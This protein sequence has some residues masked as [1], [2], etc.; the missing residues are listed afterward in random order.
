VTESRQMIITG[1][2]PGELEDLCSRLRYYRGWAA[3]IRDRKDHDDG[4]TTGPRLIISVESVDA[5]HPDEPRSTEFHFPIPACTFNRASWQRWLRDRLDDVHHHENGEALGFVYERTDTQGNPVTV[6]ER[7]FAP[8]HADGEDPHRLYE[9]GIPYEAL[10]EAQGYLQR[11]GFKPLHNGHR[12]PGFWWDGEVVHTDD[13]HDQH[14]RSC[15]PVQKD[16]D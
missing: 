3:E 7:P 2:W 1:P 14:D 8:L 9:V 15:V 6:I 4:L 11:R 13:E 10:R 16:G 5:Y 12:Y